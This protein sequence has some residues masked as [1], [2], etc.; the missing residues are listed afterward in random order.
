MEKLSRTLQEE[1]KA[2]DGLSGDVGRTVCFQCTQPLPRADTVPRSLEKEKTCSQAGLS[3]EASDHRSL[4][5][6]LFLGSRKGNT[7]S[8]GIQAWG[9]NNCVIKEEEEEKRANCPERQRLYRSAYTLG[10]CSHQS[11]GQACKWGRRAREA[12]GQVSRAGARRAGGG[13]SCALRSPVCLWLRPSSLLTN[14]GSPV[15]WTDTT[16]P[17]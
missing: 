9:C 4:S 15:S 13:H 7:S 8:L 16:A 2:S 1:R 10:V 12:A 14:M 6:P 3:T 5:V 11:L 17:H